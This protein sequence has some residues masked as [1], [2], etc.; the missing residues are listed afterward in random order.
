MRIDRA[1]VVI[2]QF[3]TKQ[4]QKKMNKTAISI[5]NSYGFTRNIIVM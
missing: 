4:K 5:N 2:I 3:V 1:K